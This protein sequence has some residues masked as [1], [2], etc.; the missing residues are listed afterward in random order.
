MY[1][2]LYIDQ[3]FVVQL[4]TGFLLLDLAAAFSGRK[5]SWKH[6]LAA[7]GINAVTVTL[8]IVL[9]ASEVI[10][11]AWLC[12]LAIAGGTVAGMLIAV[13]TV[14]GYLPTVLLLTVLLSGLQ[15]IVVRI[16]GCSVTAGMAV[17]ALLLKLA[18]PIHRKKRLRRERTAEVCLYWDE[19]QQIL[20]G[21]IDT[22]NLLQEP[23][24]GKAVSIVEKEGITVLMGKDW[25]RR[26]GFYLIPYHSIGRE[27]GWLQAVTMDKMEIRTA[28]RCVCVEH[29]VLAIYEGKLSAQKEYQIIL[30]PQ[31]V[32]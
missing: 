31:H 15:E 6:T 22:G 1:Y 26:R 2:E 27:N 10:Q 16:T 28:D 19:K 21:M 30:H 13:K 8:T 12:Q 4:L 25:Q 18:A 17:A 32:N 20:S 9:C 24:T 23:L 5:T 3:F 29:P 11:E 7:S 14:S